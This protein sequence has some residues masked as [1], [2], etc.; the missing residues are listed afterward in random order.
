MDL[1]EL[2]TRIAAKIQKE[3][4]GYRAYDDYYKTARLMMEKSLKPG[5]EMMKWLSEVMSGRLPVIVR[6]DLGLG[7]ELMGLH[8]RSL[9]AAAP[10]DFDSYMLYAEFNR[11]PDKKFY[12]PRRKILK[13]IVDD[14]QS[15]ED[16]ELDLLGISMPPGTG[17]STIALFYLTWLAGRHPD[18]PILTGSH[19]NSWVRGAYDE[20]LRIMSP[21]DDYL[22]YDVFPDVR[23]TS[24]NAK[25]CR[26]DLNKR[27]RFETLEFTSIGTGNAGL[28]RA[29]TLLY[30][31]DLVSSLE[32]AMSADRLAKLWDIYNTDLRQRKIGDRCKELHIA[33]RWS[34]FDVISRLEQ[35]YDGNPRAKFVS[36]PALNE[37]D[38]SNF[39]YQYGVGFTTKFYH[40]QRDIMDDVNWRALYMQQP[41][42]R[43]NRLYDPDELQRYF[44]LPDGEPDAIIAV[45]DTKDRGSDDCVL[46]IAY[47][48]GDR[49]Y[50]PEIICDNGK[51]EVIDE[52][53]IDALVRHKVQ[54]ACFESNSAGGRVAQIVQAGVKAKG[55]I[56]KI[57]TKYTS[58]NK[59]TK[60]LINSSWVKEHCL[61]LDDSVSSKNYKKAINKLCSYSTS[62]RNKHDD[63]PDAFA[64]LALYAESFGGARVKVIQRPW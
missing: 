55:G 5:V 24:T 33:T 28:Y 7:R 3:P 21:K 4:M 47:V 17:K 63:V 6:K 57:E 37:N 30:C 60:I 29:A 10:H 44:L 16:D 34:N 36:I 2:G 48:Y 56:T 52:L 45:C 61:F 23:V 50:I 64:Q 58:Q 14:L 22:W 9:K 32:V 1:Q 25:D 20:C 49:Y 62:S 13:F 38:E 15:L 35:I 51:P 42:E 46:P 26:I 41:I 54:T 12:V 59:E 43:Q 53:L 27:K 8:R 39:D 40:E 18:D 11:A 31:D 19:S